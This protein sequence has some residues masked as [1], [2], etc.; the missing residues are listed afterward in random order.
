MIKIKLKKL[1]ALILTVI[2]VV[3][4]SS[5][6]S[7]RTHIVEYES[8]ISETG[9]DEITVEG[10]IKGNEVF[11]T[12]GNLIG[13][14]DD[15]NNIIDADG[16]II[17][18][19]TE[20]GEIVLS[21]DVIEDMGIEIPADNNVTNT[22]GGSGS[23]GSSTA[24][25][26]KPSGAYN[27]AKDITGVKVYYDAKQSWDSSS[28]TLK[29][30]ASG[31]PTELTGL[32][33]DPS[34]AYVVRTT[35]TLAD[36]KNIAR[37]IFKGNDAFEH[38]YVALDGAN[39]TVAVY[40]TSPIYPGNEFVPIEVRSKTSSEKISLKAGTKYEVIILTS[41]GKLSVWVNGK[42]YFD[43]LD[44]N[45]G[46]DIEDVKNRAPEG[47]V[48]T[49]K[50]SRFIN[51]S[52]VFGC[53]VHNGTVSESNPVTFADLD[54][55]YTE[56]GLDSM[57]SDDGKDTDYKSTWKQ[58]TFTLASYAL[59]WEVNQSAYQSIA[60]NLKDANINL[61]I[62][63]GNPESNYYDAWYKAC[64]NAGVDF[65]ATNSS[66]YMPTMVDTAKIQSDVKSVASKYS[67][68]AG[69]YV[70]DEPDSNNY[71]KIR[72]ISQAITQVLPNKLTLTCMLPSYGSYTWTTTDNDLKYTNYIS[73]YMSK[74]KPQV[75]SM[76]YYP[77][78][79]FGINANM[80]TNG[81]W[82]D[83]GYLRYTAQ[84][85]N[86]SYWH[87][88]SAVDEWEHVTSNNMNLERISLQVNGA[89][90]YGV[91]GVAY[92]TGNQAIVKHDGSKA[93]KYDQL[94]A[95]NKQTLNIGNLLLSAESTEIY[96]STGYS[97]PGSAYLDT[98]SDSKII[99]KL[100]TAGSGIIAGVFTKGNKNYI[101][102]VN[103]DYT[104]AQTG[105][106]ELKKT[107]SVA[108]FNASTNAMG[109]AASSSNISFNISAGGIAVYELS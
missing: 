48:V 3:T 20:S 103:K 91:E 71:W 37:I 66:Y 54:V 87:I 68:C 9:E 19:V 12:E 22:S 69:Y 13:T 92:F 73:K 76:D 30:I 74:V 45:N 94:A 29:V 57:Y 4:V 109:T 105:T 25:Y 98:L 21:R 17:G 41:P 102:L 93:A 82:K 15:N 8:I 14:V 10:E 99:K 44:L 90:A 72:K 32:F 83:M 53:Y 95:F 60:K 1:L 18:Y 104:A 27:Y 100:P 65:L 79:Q 49:E 81:L 80:K 70:W 88:F 84:K 108:Q 75:L 47:Y 7:F 101:V 50:E 6:C 85:N 39:Q 56:K 64:Q 97:N 16:N 89:L 40:D 107:Y 96:H 52:N 58:N 33:M 78:Q 62:G 86:S 28:K 36:S 77:F 35:V 63:S 46:M 43:N 67:H 59:L 24:S 61:L 42:K 38:M 55:Y 5:G 11:D 34:Q 31:G 26:T 51:E 23:S 2:T 106:V